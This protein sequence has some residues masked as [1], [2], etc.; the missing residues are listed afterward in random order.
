MRIKVPDLSFLELCFKPDD[1]METV[2]S[3]GAGFLVEE[4]WDFKL[5]ETH[6]HRYLARD[7]Q[8]S[9]HGDLR[10]GAKSILLFEPV[11]GPRMPTAP[12]LKSN[13]MATAEE[14]SLRHAGNLP[15]GKSVD[16][17]NGS[18]KME[19]PKGKTKKLTPGKLPKWFK[20]A[21]K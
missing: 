18:N 14:L 10:F 8:G 19:A 16:I 15:S 3:K 7:T 21:R 2:Y 11:Q 20:I 12:F 4:T 6:P 9:L 1:T 13:I 5:S 17:P